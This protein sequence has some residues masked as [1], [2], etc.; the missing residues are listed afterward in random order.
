MKTMNR[1]TTE[2][3]LTDL[4]IM[5]IDYAIPLPIM[6]YYTNYRLRTLEKNFKKLENRLKEDSKY[7]ISKE[8]IL[9]EYIE[10]DE[11]QEKV[12]YILC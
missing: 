3:A 1:D 6:K 10:T 7:F 5:I 9:H 12:S 2:K 8:S 11:F 4:A